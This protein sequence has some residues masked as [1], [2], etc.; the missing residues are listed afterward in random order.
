MNFREKILQRKIFFLD[1][2]VALF[3]LVLDRISKSAVIVLLNETSRE[4]GSKHAQLYIS[5]LVSIVLVWNRGGSF[6]LF[7][8]VRFIS[9]L[10][11]ILSLLT[12]AMLIFSLWISTNVYDG[13]YMSLIIGGALGNAIDRILYGAVVDFIDVHIGP[14]HWPSFNLADSSILCGV[15]LY[16]VNDYLLAKKHSKT[17][18]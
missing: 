6:G 18:R 12:S 17:H 15:I 13:L 14:Y 5:K 7:A 2:A 3:I 4:I 9:I 16:I 10:L 1:L 8:G 11:L